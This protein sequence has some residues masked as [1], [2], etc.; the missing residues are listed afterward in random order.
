[1]QVLVSQVVQR[2]SLELPM[3][4]LVRVS[5][6]GRQQYG[7]QALCRNFG[8]SALQRA[9]H[10]L[11]MLKHDLHIH[12]ALATSA[13]YCIESGFLLLVLCVWYAEPLAAWQCGILC[14]SPLA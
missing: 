6:L 2:S 9:S 10:H 11:F 14:Q 8:Y 3:S 4:M 5:T 12:A 1:M 13:Y 7:V